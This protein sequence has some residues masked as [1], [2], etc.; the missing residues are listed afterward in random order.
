MSLVQLI[1]ISQ[2]FGFDSSILSGILWRARINNARDNITGALIARADIY[3]QL[4]EGPEA[5]V[6]RTWAKIRQD[7]RHIDATRKVLRPITTRM[8][9]YWTMHDD[10]ADTWLWDQAEVADGA[11][12]AATE[13]D[14]LAVFARMREAALEGGPGPG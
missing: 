10:P 3:I 13:D 1:Y 4:L 5:D 11:A 9:P 12:A 14:M 2:P 7:D 6:L 8:F